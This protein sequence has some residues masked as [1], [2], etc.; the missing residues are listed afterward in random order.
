MSTG[1]DKDFYKAIDGIN[2]A[3]AVTKKVDSVFI[4]NVKHVDELINSN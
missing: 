1:G 2:I 4:F 3:G